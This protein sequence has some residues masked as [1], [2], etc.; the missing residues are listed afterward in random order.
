M[1]VIESINIY[2]IQFKF[3]NVSDMTLFGTFL[4]FSPSGVEYYDFYQE[5]C[6][7]YLKKLER[8]VNAGL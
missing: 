7:N 3:N 8:E 4:F 2:S 5:V 1:N 6:T